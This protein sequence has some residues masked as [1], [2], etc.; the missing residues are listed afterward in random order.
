MNVK[1]NAVTRFLMI[2]ILGLFMVFTALAAEA[3]PAKSTQAEINHLLDFVQQSD[4][5]YNRNGSAHKGPEARK[6]IERKLNYYWDDILTTEDFIKLAATKSELSGRV[7]TV[8]CP[9]QPEQTS[10]AWLTRELMKYREK[11]Q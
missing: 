10:N 5:T 4:C 1:N 3:S 9:N 8:K 6:H 2:A 11:G 7:Y